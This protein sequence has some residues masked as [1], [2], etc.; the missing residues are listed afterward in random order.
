MADL[1]HRC[2][3]AEGATCVVG[4]SGEGKSS[5]LRLLNR[6]SDPAAGS[7]RYGGRDVRDFNVLALRRE[8]ALVPQ[9]PALLEGCVAD[10]A[11]TC[12]DHDDA[13]REAAVLIGAAEADRIRH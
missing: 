7:V 5:L 11:K 4:P 13:Y 10:N 12:D 2:G 8:V 1:A 3:I 6:M 9:V